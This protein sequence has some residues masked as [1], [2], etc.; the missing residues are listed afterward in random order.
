MNMN[1]KEAFRYQN[2]L[3]TLLGEAM[4]IL[5]DNNNVTLVTSTHLRHKVMPEVEDE[6]ITEVPSSEYS[7]QITQVARLIMYLLEQRELLSHAIRAAK[8]SMEVDF[9]SE[10]SLNRTRQ[11]LATMFR[12]MGE[13]RSS[14]VV[15]PRMGRGYRF[16]ADG[17]QVEYRCDLRKVT[18]INFDRNLVRKFANDLSSR[19][20]QMS[21]RLDQC[22]VN[23]PV[24]YQ[25]PF[26]V[27][28][29]FSEVLEWHTGCPAA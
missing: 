12:H 2:R 14:E 27:S 4:C 6:T 7:Q 3:G 16:N 13:I 8:Q 28:C 29:T 20:D 15:L 17:N 10:I 11:D 18:T 26:D 25:P 24:D 23:T 1:L 9:D 19:A 22:L 21:T 5:A